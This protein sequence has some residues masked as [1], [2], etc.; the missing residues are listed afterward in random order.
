MDTI[1]TSNARAVETRRVLHAHWVRMRARAASQP[2]GALNLQEGY[3][4][5][6]EYALELLGGI[7]DVEDA[8]SG[9]TAVA[10]RPSGDPR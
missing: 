2:G 1:E 4:L 10:G 5:G 8:D 7:G 6:I 3:L 9:A